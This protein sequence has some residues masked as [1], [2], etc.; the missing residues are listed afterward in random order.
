[1]TITLA[2]LAWMRTMREPS[3]PA[4]KGALRPWSKSRASLDVYKRQFADL[5]A[6]LIEK[7]ASELDIENMSA[8]LVPCDRMINVEVDKKDSDSKQEAVESKIAA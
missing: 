5:L 6:N 7:Y 2:R 4:A 3:G 1:M 8:S